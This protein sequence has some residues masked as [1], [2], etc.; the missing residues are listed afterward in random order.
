MRGLAYSHTV[1]EESVDVVSGVFTGD[2]LCSELTIVAVAV[3]S[4]RVLAAS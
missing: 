4:V 3:D 2:I 1:F